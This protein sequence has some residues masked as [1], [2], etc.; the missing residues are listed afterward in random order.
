MAVWHPRVSWRQDLSMER[1][2]LQNQYHCSQFIADTKLWMD[3]KNLWRRRWFTHG[4]G[5]VS[6]VY[7]ATARKHLLNGL[8]FAKKCGVA[9]GNDLARWWYATHL[10]HDNLITNIHQSDGCK[11]AKRNLQYGIEW[12]AATIVRV[13]WKRFWIKTISSLNYC[14]RKSC[15]TIEIHSSSHHRSRGILN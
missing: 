10:I 7:L 3:V 4:A 13:S 1:R 5:Y 15:W 8:I 11:V 6:F 12:I 2:T 9:R 14:N